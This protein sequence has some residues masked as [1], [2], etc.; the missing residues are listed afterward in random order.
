[1]F[2]KSNEI[3]SET[4]TE[5]EISTISSNN[6]ILPVNQVV[7]LPTAYVY[8][9]DING[10]LQKCRILI[11]SAS[12]GSFVKESFV[13]LLRLKR[14]KVNI[15]VDGLSSQ[16]INNVSG[17]VQLQIFSQFYKQASITVEALIIPI[18]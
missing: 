11:D 3:K 1:M 6:A 14:N 17:S 10:A 9:K 8:V 5:S 12:Q 16:K 15:S 4:P 13:N 18:M 2:K 7:L